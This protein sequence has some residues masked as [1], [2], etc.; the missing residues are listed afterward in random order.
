MS[1]WSSEIEADLHWR[2]VE[3]ASLKALC[4]KLDERSDSY[5]AMLRALW[6]L[7]YAHYEGFH[8]FCWDLMLDAIESECVVRAAMSETFAK[9]SLSKAFRGLRGDGSAD[10]FWQFANTGFAS[11]MSEL[12]SFPE[13]LETQSNLWPNILIE[14]NSKVGISCGYVEANRVKL[15]SIVHRRNEIAH[16]KKLVISRL[17]E[18]QDYENA[19]F[20]VMHELAVL[21]I[22]CLDRR[23]YL[24]FPALPP[25][26]RTT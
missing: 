22:D 14:N 10:S 9:L 5:R 3:L 26:P 8:K 18:Y 23:S 15:Q 11:K 20:L 17:S 2:E 4:V 25:P 12:A 1:T 7:M 21:V 13:K 19:A 16:G 6:A 24:A